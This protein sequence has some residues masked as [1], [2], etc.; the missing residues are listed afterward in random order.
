M[1]A[2]LPSTSQGTRHR[3]TT[4]SSAL[5]HTP[6]ESPS[7]NQR[8]KPPSSALKPVYDALSLDGD[9]DL[10]NISGDDT[11][12]ENDFDRVPPAT[13][14]TSMAMPSLSRGH[15]HHLHD[16]LSSAST[17]GT[18][19]SFTAQLGKT[20]L[21][22]RSISVQAQRANESLGQVDELL[23]LKDI[24]TRAQQQ[25][26]QQARPGGVVGA[27]RTVTKIQ[28]IGKSNRATPETTQLTFDSAFS[29]L[30]GVL[31][32][33]ASTMRA[34]ILDD[35]FDEDSSNANNGNVNNNNNNN[36][37]FHSLDPK[38]RA[39]IGSTRSNNFLTPLSRAGSRR[40][41]ARSGTPMTHELESCWSPVEMPRELKPTAGGTYYTKQRF[42]QATE[43]HIR[44]SAAV[45][46][47]ATKL[48]VSSML[49][50]LRTDWDRRSQFSSEV[51]K[52]RHER[53]ETS[54]RLDGSGGVVDWQSHNRRHAWKI[55][56]RK[57][58]H[59]L[60][61]ETRK[62]R[63]REVTKLHDYILCEHL[64]EKEHQ[65]SD[66][67]LDRDERHRAMSIAIGLARSLRV[68]A[69]VVECRRRL[70]DAPILA[71]MPPD[72]ID[73]VT[74]CTKRPTI[75]I[76]RAEAIL[77]RNLWRFVLSF[78]I[79]R[80]RTSVNFI[81]SALMSS[82]GIM[83]VMRRLRAYRAGVITLQRWFRSQRRRA[84]AW[85]ELI[86][87]QLKKYQCERKSFLEAQQ[88]IVKLVQES[89][90]A[91]EAVPAADPTPKKKARKASKHGLNSST[92]GNSNSSHN[93]NTTTSLTFD[94]DERRH[95]HRLGY[96]D[97]LLDS[98]TL[99]SEYISR[100]D[101]LGSRG[102]PNRVLYIVARFVSAS[103]RRSRRQTSLLVGDASHLLRPLE[104]HVCISCACALT[105]KERLFRERTG[106]M[107][108]VDADYDLPP[109]TATPT[110]SSLHVDDNNNTSLEE[111]L[112]QVVYNWP[113]VYATLWPLVP[114]SGFRRALLLHVP[115]EFQSEFGGQHQ[116][117]HH[118][119]KQQQ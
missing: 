7:T 93:V 106:M 99:A 68:F 81:L 6:H 40:A 33:K 84:W 32:K 111:E 21:P 96:S 117:Q 110:A 3:P 50:T 20:E 52:T 49:Y 88:K 2:T 104:A 37:S 35:A 43:H 17:L 27:A 60:W 42:E 100:F 71:L 45:R 90:K 67:R 61:H 59:Q 80:K 53:A 89:H 10:A 5:R 95:L 113:S 11:D 13:A 118:H 86:Y 57:M 47:K 76:E 46:R 44:T 41:L 18:S 92:M 69:A 85:S 54:A 1:S 78:R 26:E 23:T 38:G 107:L 101:G 55:K 25:R 8:A 14:P 75:G 83:K 114:D 64:Q 22:P 4:K 48:Y 28:S 116:Y 39:G 31:D 29:A 94:A 58:E 109:V 16:R 65:L 56:D 15:H 103:I 66:N 87:L 12:F 97:D 77:R 62:E 72:F 82:R 30:S 91:N 34:G 73:H 112:E 19:R 51:E 9:G 79:R 74:T 98:F 70:T 108:M 105:E 119:Q 115:K 63:A 102:I 24:R 36:A